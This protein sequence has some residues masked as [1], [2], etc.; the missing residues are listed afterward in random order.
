VKDVVT[1]LQFQTHC[2]QA[3]IVDLDRLGKE[4]LPKGTVVK[5]APRKYEREATIRWVSSHNGN[6][7]IGVTDS[8]SGKDVVTDLEAIA[9]CYLEAESREKVT[10]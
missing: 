8:E 10:I 3:A 1:R 9:K 2:C 4:L 7:R 5:Y 6:L